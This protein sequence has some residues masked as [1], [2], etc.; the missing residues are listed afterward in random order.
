MEQRDDA[1][2]LDHLVR[3]EIAQSLNRDPAREGLLNRERKELIVEDQLCHSATWNCDQQFVSR[4]AWSVQH[5]AA[6]GRAPRGRSPPRRRPATAPAN[7][8]GADQSCTPETAWRAPH[9]R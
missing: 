6:G 2:I 3:A 8:P 7:L 4:Y 1:L 5:T 9:R